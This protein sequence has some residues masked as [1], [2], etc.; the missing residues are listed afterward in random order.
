MSTIP[1]CPF[2]NYRFWFEYADVSDEWL[3]EVVAVSS[4][5][6][7]TSQYTSTY[8]CRSNIWWFI[9]G[10]QDSYTFVVCWFASALGESVASL[11]FL[12]MF[13]G[14]HLEYERRLQPDDSRTE[15]ATYSATP[16][17]AGMHSHT[18]FSDKHIHFPS[19]FLSLSTWTCWSSCLKLQQKQLQ[20]D[21]LQVCVTPRRQTPYH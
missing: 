9:W 20:L 12:Y 11:F 8:G 5:M 3:V 13:F 2:H 7:S 16:I 4:N 15:P 21:M 17:T 1:S 10:A 6:K 18:C 14:I 19:P